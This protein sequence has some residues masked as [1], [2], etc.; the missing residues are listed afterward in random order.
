MPQ[1]LKRA[2]S[3]PADT[4]LPAAATLTDNFATPTAPAVGAFLMV[5]DGSAWDMA[6]GDDTDGLLV[7]L[8]SNNDVDVTDR[9]ARD[10]GK[11][12]I[13]AFDGAV[14]PADTF[15]TPT[16]SPPVV[17]FGMV[18]NGTTWDMLRG[19]VANGVLVNLGTNNDVDTELPSAVLLGGTTEFSDP[20]VPAVGAYGVVYD[21]GAGTWR[22]LA[23]WHV[24][25]LSRSGHLGVSP[26]VY[27]G[28]TWDR[29]RALAEPNTITGRAIGSQVVG[30]TEG[31]A[32]YRISFNDLVVVAGVGVNILGHANAVVRVTRI[33]ISKPSVA[34][35]PCRFVKTSAAATGG[36]QTAPTPILLDSANE[37]AV[38]VVNLYTAAP[39]GGAEVGSVFEGDIGAA[40]VVDE[41]FGDEQNTQALVLRG[42][43][44]TL[45]ID[46]SAGATINGLLEWTEE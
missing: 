28:A 44:Q 30:K 12:D 1:P 25:G 17:A 35:A 45:E 10:L 24:D 46:L 33:Q 39:T 16:A 31:K 40:D 21:Q 11:V 2:G 43:A 34:Q 26:A 7:N 19:D 37:A 5:Y 23:T 18:Y 14:T 6:R 42:A 9:A 32:T 27:N 15:T 20:T 41:T 36:T 38:A 3:G 13:A 8:G 29:A 22:G 4:E